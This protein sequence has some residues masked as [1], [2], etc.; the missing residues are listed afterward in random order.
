MNRELLLTILSSIAQQ[1]V[2]TIS[3]NV[4]MGLKMKMKR[5]G[6]IGYNGSLG[7]DYHPVD[8]SITVNEKEAETVRLIFDLYLQGYGAYTIAKKL[9]AMGI[10]SK[11]SH[12][13]DKE[14]I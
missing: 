11:N 1:D 12:K 2:E 4:K 6:L 5:G 13:I 14:I 3:A 10:P 8:K 7:Y 9:T